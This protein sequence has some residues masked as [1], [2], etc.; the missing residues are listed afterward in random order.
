[1]RL[2]QFSMRNI[3]SH[4]RNYFLFICSIAFNVSIYYVFLSLFDTLK[5]STRYFDSFAP[6]FAIGNFIILIFCWIF[7]WYCL[8]YFISKRHKEIGLFLLLGIRKRNISLLLILESFITSSLGVILGLIS[9]VIIQRFFTLLLFHIVGL[10]LNLPFH[11]SLS[12]LSYTVS[13]F[14]YLILL[15]TAML[16]FKIRKWTLMSLFYKT[17]N[18]QSSLIIKFIGGILGIFLILWGYK[19]ALSSTP[20]TFI[21][22]MII[23]LFIVVIG[24]GFFVIH[25]CSLMT[26]L[27]KKINSK[28]HIST[29]FY[30]WQSLPAKFHKY[31]WLL[32]LVSILSATT[33]TILGTSLSMS[34]IQDYYLNQYYPYDLSIIYN[35][36]NFYNEISSYLKSE[37][38][39]IILDKENSFALNSIEVESQIMISGYYYDSDYRDSLFVKYSDLKLHRPNLPEIKDDEVLFYRNTFLESPSYTGFLKLDGRTFDIKMLKS[40]ITNYNFTNKELVVVSDSLFD[41][42]DKNNYSYIYNVYFKNKGSI[43]QNYAILSSF[44]NNFDHNSSVLKAYYYISIGFT[45]SS[46]SFVALF[47]SFVFLISMGSVMYFKLLGNINVDMKNITL[48]SKLGMTRTDIRR[49]IALQLSYL[50]V[51]PL[52]I[53]IIHSSIAII[54]F[55]QIIYLDLATAIK[56]NLIIYCPLYILYYLITIKSYYNAIDQELYIQN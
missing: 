31:R 33:L 37:N 2:W 40:P 39:D 50:L 20:I 43:E 46:Y 25:F 19:I 51:I 26:S 48:L 24:T 28:Y 15:V 16:Y 23:T 4:I 13:H 44:L 9:G 47:V 12:S 18:K 10:E 7:I 35:D 53:G 36:N 38:T 55:S 8:D 56:H 22:N 6:L 54:S 17:D 29:N 27:I 1:M 52:V 34:T 41:S 11:I 45:L 30:T 14:S 5:A 3:L 32:F 49:H 42:L 21:P